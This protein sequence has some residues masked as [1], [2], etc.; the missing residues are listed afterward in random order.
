[1]GSRRLGCSQLQRASAVTSY[2][3]LPQKTPQH[4]THTSQQLTAA[5]TA[6]LHITT[7]LIALLLRFVAPCIRVLRAPPSAD[8]VKAQGNWKKSAKVSPPLTL[9]LSPKS[10]QPKV[11]PNT[12]PNRSPTSSPYLNPSPDPQPSPHPGPDPSPDPSL[13]P[14]AN[15]SSNP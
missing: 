3:S 13:N 4:P 11:E 15:L 2:S 1:M 5:H 6:S 12:K 10:T 14:I 9:T 8:P 7:S